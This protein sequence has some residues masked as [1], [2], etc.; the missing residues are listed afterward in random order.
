MTGIGKGAHLSPTLRAGSLRPERR[1]DFLTV[2]QQNSAQP[3]PKPRCPYPSHAP[4]IFSRIWPP[5][6]LSSWEGG[7][8]HREWVAEFRGETSA[9]AT[10]IPNQGTHKSTS[11]GRRPRV[12]RWE[13]PA[14]GRQGGDAEERRGAGARYPAPHTACWDSTLRAAPLRKFAGRV[15]QSLKTCRAERKK[16]KMRE[17]ARPGGREGKSPAGG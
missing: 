1:S 17:G 14:W 15:H 3:G 16:G 5:A 9:P 10:V 2:T 8:V 4:A 6:A 11:R 12:P 13:S 7:E